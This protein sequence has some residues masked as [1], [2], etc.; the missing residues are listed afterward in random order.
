M[1]SPAPP[2]AWPTP[3]TGRTRSGRITG[4]L[5]QLFVTFGLVL[6]LFAAYELW[7]KAAVVNAHQADLER[8]LSQ[9]WDTVEPPVPT[10]AVSAAPK[11]KPAAPKPAFAPLPGGA[12]ARLTIPKLK[13]HWVVVQGVTPYDIRYAPGHYPDSAMPGEVGNFAV[14]GHRTPGIF[15]DLDQIGSGDIITVETR[16]AVFTYRVTEQ[17]IVAPTAV[18]VVAPVPFHPDEAPVDRWLT[19]TTCNPKWDNYQRLVV[20]AI[21]DHTDLRTNTKG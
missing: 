4:S 6:A 8:A 21:L 14:A 19:L 15:W 5:G 7:G 16:A 11:A 10:P 1:H 3:A 9:Q 2:A 12:V 18:E 17:V 20:H 13:K